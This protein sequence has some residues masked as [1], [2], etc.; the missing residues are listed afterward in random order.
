MGMGSGGHNKSHRTI[1][2]YRRV[3]SFALRRFMD[4]NEGSRWAVFG[5]A[6]IYCDFARGLVDISQGGEYRPLKLDKAG[7]SGETPSRL[8]FRCPR[9][10]RRTRYLYNYHGY[11]V[12]RQCLGANYASQQR[13]RGLEAIRRRMRKLVERDL[14]YPQWRIDNPN[15]GISELGIIPRPRYM[16]WAKYSRLMMEY[17]ELQDEHTRQFL[18]LCGAFLP[19]GWEKEFADL[20]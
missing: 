13:N 3:D 10:D 15:R 16:R 5:R 6:T 12:C 20:M 4:D 9:C 2:D 18:K 8:Y 19:P 1:E 7:G 14:Q 11:H 17:R